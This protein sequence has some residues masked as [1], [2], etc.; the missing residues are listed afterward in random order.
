MP[1]KVNFIQLE[2]EKIKISNEGEQKIGREF[3]KISSNHKK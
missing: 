1:Q 3:L 2:T